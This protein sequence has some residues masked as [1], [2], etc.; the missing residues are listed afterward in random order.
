V[1]S[2]DIVSQ[3]LK[4]NLTIFT[5]K[6]SELESTVMPASR[7][8]LR[9][10]A[11][12]HGNHFDDHCIVLWCNCASIGVMGASR[13]MFILSYI[14]NVLA[15]FPLNSVCVLVHPNRAGQQEGRQVTEWVL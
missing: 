9:E 12:E 1:R 14:T 2:W 3:F 15:D 6:G 8:W 4:E 13:G 5:G 7:A 10:V 11:A